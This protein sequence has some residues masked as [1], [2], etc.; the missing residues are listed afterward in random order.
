MPYIPATAT[1]LQEPRELIDLQITNAEIM[2][3]E[4]ACD[5]L[6]IEAGSIGH[7]GRERS[8]Q[9]KGKLDLD[10]RTILPGFIDSHTHLVQVGL[11]ALR[12]DLSRVASRKEA[13]GA[14]SEK[15]KAEGEPVIV[16]YGWD[17]SAWGEKE[18][19]TR[20]E[21]DF[22]SKPVVLYRM[23]EHMAVANSV[24][25]RKVG[26]EARKD[27]ILR[28]RELEALEVLVEPTPE[29]RRQAL[30]VALK[31]ALHLGVTTARD[32]VD[33]ATI[34]AYDSLHSVPIRIAVVLHDGE[35]F[36]GFA[37]RQGRWGTK[38][39]LDGSIGASTAAV[40]GWPAGNLLMDESA[41]SEL[42]ARRW[43]QG[44]PVAAHAI[45]DVA[46]RVAV[47]AF[48]KYDGRLRNSVEHM[49]LL[50]EDLIQLRPNIVASCQPN[51]LQ[52]SLP[53]GLYERRLGG[54]W[55]ARNNPYRLLLDAGAHLAFGSDCMPFNPN[56]GIHLAVN[57]PFS[58]QRISVEEAVRCYTSEGAYL[59]GMEGSVGR[60]EKGY[61]A[62]LIVLPRGYLREKERIKDQEVLATIVRGEIIHD[63]LK[64]GT[65]GT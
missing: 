22:T 33:A 35:F 54:E 3:S 51:F 4:G 36:S 6:E 44:L 61:F 9:A 28:E 48:S 41:L 65:R 47:E 39:F 19:L 37:G 20:G 13:L 24:A 8:V 63:H 49:E 23:D 16:G 60:I 58:K 34:S 18:Y 29:V 15:S 5:S 21:L 52:W 27:G 7:V 17:E 62:D 64:L 46:A 30:E 2:S 40:S 10:G 11:S 56:Y 12:L 1:S 53:G 26:L 42:A 55:L 32:I 38:T 14:V 45:G 59:L 25:L 31:K 50:D 57:S 43:R